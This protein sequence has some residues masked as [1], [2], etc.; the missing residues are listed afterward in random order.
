MRLK[1]ILLPALAFTLAFGSTALGAGWKQDERGWRYE[2]EDGVFLVK[3]WYEDMDDSWYFFDEQGYMIDHTYRK[4]NDS[5]YAFGTSGKWTGGIYPMAQTGYWQ[6][7]QYRNDWSDITVNMPDGFDAH[8]LET[9][10]GLVEATDALVQIVAAAGGSEGNY[11]AMFALS[12]VELS[13]YEALLNPEQSDAAQTA[14]LVN[15]LAFKQEGYVI[16]TFDWIDAGSKR[17]AYFVAHAGGENRLARYYRQ[18]AE[19]YIEE[20]SVLYTPEGKSYVDALM[21]NIS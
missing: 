15:A 5:V 20:L 13:A 4:I 14:A 12:Y 10:T 21:A 2:R 8:L 11:D 9:Q 6:G 17:Y 3:T 18:S 16:E 7:N 1:R 19:R